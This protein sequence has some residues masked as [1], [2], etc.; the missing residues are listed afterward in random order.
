MTLTAEHRN[1]LR[2]GFSS[3]QT[4]LATEMLSTRLG[5][6]L[7]KD[8]VVNESAGAVAEAVLY[9]LRDG[10]LRVTCATR[11]DG[12]GISG[13]T[14]ATVRVVDA[15][16]GTL[17]DA[18]EI[19][20]PRISIVR[21]EPA[22]WSHFDLVISGGTVAPGMSESRRPDGDFARFTEALEV[23]NALANNLREFD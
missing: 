16:G 21:R 19:G 4:R 10:G 3:P 11:R 5:T 1:G 13:G 20:Q 12:G 6:H 17:E 15:N 22:I 7:V 23:A 8:E 14:V 9:V 2:T 18:V